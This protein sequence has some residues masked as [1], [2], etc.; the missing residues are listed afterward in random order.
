MYKD[1]KNLIKQVQATELVI[2]NIF[3]HGLHDSKTIEPLAGG[4][5]ICLMA[6]DACGIRLYKIEPG[7]WKH[8]IGAKGRKDTIKKRV[9]QIVC[10]F[11]GIPEYQ[12]KTDD[13][14]DALGMAACWKFQATELRNKKK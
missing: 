13:H 7:T 9:K 14:S 1:I 2:E 12:I 5:V 10:R 6:A 3:Y 8:A 4:A 11:W